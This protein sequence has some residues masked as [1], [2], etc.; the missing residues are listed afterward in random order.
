MDKVCPVVLRGEEL[1]VFR[2]PLAGC[3]L[4]KGGI[5]LGE[6]PLDAASRELAEESGLRLPPARDLGHSDRITPSQRWH[7]WLMGPTSDTLPESWIHCTQDDGGHD[8]AFFWLPLGTPSPQGS[9]AL[10]QRAADTIA[11]ALA[12]GKPVS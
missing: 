4:V 5:E 11:R 7:F 2:H 12:T 3:Q 8:F 1:L 6:T 10:F 9:A